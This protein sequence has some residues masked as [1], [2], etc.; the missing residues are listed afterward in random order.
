MP[1]ESVVMTLVSL[2]YLL[3]SHSLHAATRSVDQ[4]CS[5][6]FGRPLQQAKP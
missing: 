3:H 6:Q 2:Q 5:Y 1:A 4:G